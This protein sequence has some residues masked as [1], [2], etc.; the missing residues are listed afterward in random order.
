[1]G[2]RLDPT[3]PETQALLESHQEEVRDQIMYYLERIP[4]PEGERP[5]EVQLIGRFKISQLDALLA[6]ALWDGNTLHAVTVFRAFEHT[7]GTV[8]GMVDTPMVYLICR[9][10]MANIGGQPGIQLRWIFP[11]DTVLEAV[12]TVGY[13]EGAVAIYSTIPAAIDKLAKKFFSGR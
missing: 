11:D 1:M 2:R 12:S 5:C 3:D 9:Y 6:T 10:G 4:S 13:L 7:T 8:R